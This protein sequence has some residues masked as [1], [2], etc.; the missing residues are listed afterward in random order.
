MVRYI[1]TSESHILSA[2]ETDS[3]LNVINAGEKKNKNKL[4]CLPLTRSVSCTSLVSL[5]TP[6]SNSTSQNIKI[7]NVFTA[8]YL[9]Y[10][11]VGMFKEKK[12]KAFD[13]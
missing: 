2:S 9:L 8:G 11:L 1:Q 3:L 5:L 10:I 13:D 7:Y 12:N 6:R 4:M